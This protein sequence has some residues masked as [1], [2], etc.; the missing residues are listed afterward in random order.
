[1]ERPAFYDWPRVAFNLA[2][3][4]ALTQKMWQNTSYLQLGIMHD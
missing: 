1:V 3:P 2:T 4:L